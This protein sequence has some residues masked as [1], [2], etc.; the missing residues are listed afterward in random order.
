[1]TDLQSLVQAGTRN[2]ELKNIRAAAGEVATVGEPSELVSY[3][4]MFAAACVALGEVSELLGLDPDQGGAAPIIIAIK[5]L[6]EAVQ[7]A[8]YAVSAKPYAYEFSRSNG[9]GTYSVV[10]ERGSLVEV[11]PRKFE[12]AEPR[13]ASNDMP[14]KP[15]YTDHATNGD[16]KDSERFVRFW[17]ALLDDDVAFV[18]AFE[19]WPDEAKTLDDVRKKIDAAILASKGGA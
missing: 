9:D 13:Y 11:A 17:Q 15:L 8:P 12:Y 5:E 14:I 7:R 1:M 3:K 6:Q 4:R 19:N 16:A 2:L 10:I 18:K